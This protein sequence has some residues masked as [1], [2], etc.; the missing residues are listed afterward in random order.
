MRIE[1]EIGA[2]ASDRDKRLKAA[3]KAIKDSRAAVTASRAGAKALEDR[4]KA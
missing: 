1:K 2:F 4:G 3:E